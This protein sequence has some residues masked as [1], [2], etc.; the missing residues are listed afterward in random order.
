MSE[1]QATK[2]DEICRW[3]MQS[4]DISAVGRAP[5]IDF[6]LS[7]DCYEITASPPG[8]HIRITAITEDGEVSRIVL[9]N[10]LTGEAFA[11]IESTRVDALSVGEDWNTASAHATE[12]AAALYWSMWRMQQV[13]AI[14]PTTP[15]EGRS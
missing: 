2:D 11:D 4:M 6:E 3:T 10:T 9:T 15:T 5:S 1:E 13:K 7:K 12:I 14:R 8:G